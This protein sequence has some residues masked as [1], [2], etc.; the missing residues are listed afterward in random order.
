VFSVI[1]VEDSE[2]LSRINNQTSVELVTKAVDAGS[3]L[4]K[5][6]GLLALR[7]KIVGWHGKLEDVRAEMLATH[8]TEADDCENGYDY[9]QDYFPWVIQS[10]IPHF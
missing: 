9:N 10:N 7:F 2:F 8:Q 5:F 6:V 4:Q 1:C 3:N